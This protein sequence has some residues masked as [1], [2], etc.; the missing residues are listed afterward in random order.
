[1]NADFPNP[2][3]GRCAAP[4]VEDES[5]QCPIIPVPGESYCWVHGGAK[6]KPEL[7]DA[8]Q[9]GARCVFHA[10]EPGKNFT[11]CGDEVVCPTH[12]LA[13]PWD[14]FRVGRCL[15]CQRLLRYGHR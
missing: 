12:D 13:I 3:P 14:A 5:K 9:L 1:M 15:D 10:V 8:V 6:R 2:E 4:R 11:I 7:V